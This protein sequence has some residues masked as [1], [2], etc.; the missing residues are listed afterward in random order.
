M[1]K[2][3]TKFILLYAF[4]YCGFSFGAVLDIE[5]KVIDAIKNG[6]TE[7]DFRYRYE[8]V[9]QRILKDAYANTVR[10]RLSYK[11]ANFNGLSAVFAFSNVSILGQQKFNSSGGTSGSKF[12]YAVV[13]DPENSAVYKAYLNY[14]TFYNT[15]IKFGRQ[16]I[17]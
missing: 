1:K 17:N 10:S 2:I 15:N 6:E 11:T 7:L 14:K 3:L 9:H 13:A 16:T 12:R 8:N 4:S 5:N